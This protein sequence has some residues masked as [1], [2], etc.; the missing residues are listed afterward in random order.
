MSSE[1]TDEEVH[2]KPDDA[3]PLDPEESLPYFETSPN[4]AD[5]TEPKHALPCPL[6]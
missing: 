4:D 2:A 6:P 1:D 5:P 3:D